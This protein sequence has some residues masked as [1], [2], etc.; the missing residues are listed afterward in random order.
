MNVMEQSSSISIV[1]AGVVT[2][3]CPCLLRWILKLWKL[4]FQVNFTGGGREEQR[5]DK[6]KR[7]RE[8]KSPPDGQLGRGIRKDKWE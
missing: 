6:N 5:V 2:G 3:R 7:E 1:A 4:I 8:T